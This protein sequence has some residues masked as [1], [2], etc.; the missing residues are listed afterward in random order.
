MGKIIC[1][2]FVFFLSA[3]NLVTE[4]SS[5]DQAVSD[6]ANFL[7][8]ADSNLVHDSGR[9]LAASEL[10][11]D[12][13]FPYVPNE[14]FKLN[15][16]IRFAN[17]VTIGISPQGGGYVNYGSWG[18]NENFVSPL[19]GR[20]WQVAIRDAMHSGRYNPTQAGTNAW[21]G[22]S[23]VL[24]RAKQ[25]KVIRVKPFAIPLFQ[26]ADY[27][28]FVQNE[29]PQDGKVD[30]NLD[31][32]GRTD[33][34]A[35]DEW[36]SSHDEE[37]TSEFVY[38]GR[39]E[40]LSHLAINDRSTA[41]MRTSYLILYAKEPK[42]INQFLPFGNK[43]P[44][45]LKN[46]SALYKHSLRWMNDLSPNLVG[47]Q[48]V[49]PTDL[50]IIKHHDGIRF[51][52]P[53]GRCIKGRNTFQIGLGGKF[54]ERD[55]CSVKKGVTIDD[56]PP[57]L[58]RI[59]QNTD[60]KRKVL[61]PNLNV[62]DA[63]MNQFNQGQPFR[64]T[65]DINYASLVISYKIGPN[66]YVAYF[67]PE[68]N[69]N[70]NSVV[71]VNKSN[72]NLLYEEDRNLV[73]SSEFN[74]AILTQATLASNKAVAGLLSPVA[75][76]KALSEAA[77]RKKFGLHA[78]VS[79]NFAEGI[80]QETYVVFGRSLR[81]VHQEVWRLNRSLRWR[82][83]NTKVPCSVLNYAARRTA[84]FGKVTSWTRA[85]HE[86]VKEDWETKGQYLPMMCRPAFV[87]AEVY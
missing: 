14:D 18:S 11:T 71:A 50:S 39:Y 80:R 4:T 32:G 22:R 48:I 47:N 23:A 86:K 34:D 81:S 63:L 38:A 13:Q 69:M 84:V 60:L 49:S 83:V 45:V 52:I 82:D 36:G 78:K 62:S 55:V 29:E 21:I 9:V 27:F 26:D 37:I 43:V 57:F 61:N 59:S 73:F 19:F 3:C 74:R 77:N 12:S 87:K 33:G 16:N 6:M 1:V 20:G 51:K 7:E 41:I 70:I 10:I 42:S 44:R 64:D 56:S 40:N 24:D 85:L 30:W 28:D 35:I 5:P 17:G 54:R 68:S 15:S 2:P 53:K 67:V 79:P 75:L 72:G 8:G 66:K 58:S 25:G 65:S 46:N 31:D 76:N